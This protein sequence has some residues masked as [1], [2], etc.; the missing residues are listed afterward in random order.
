MARRYD[1]RRLGAD[2][3]RVVAEWYEA[4]GYTVVARNWRCSDGE[5]DLILAMGTTVVFCEV[6][7]RSSDRFGTPFDAVGP[8][9]R[10][11]L[12][13]LAGRWLREA[14][15]FRPTELRFDVAGVVGRRVDVIES[16]L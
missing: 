16:A 3:E 9:K 7:T 4:R 5:L 8:D 1:S 11:R 6:K 13:R 12:R 14:A 10:R 15:P 2:G